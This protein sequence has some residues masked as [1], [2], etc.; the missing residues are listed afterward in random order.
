MLLSQAEHDEIARAIAD[1]ETRTSGEIFCIVTQDV[2]TYPQVPLA[3]GAV[4]AFLLP[5]ALLFAGVDPAALLPF[6]GEW[7]AA[8]TTAAAIAARTSLYAYVACQILVFVVVMLLG[9]IRAVRRMMTPRWLKRERVHKAALEQFLAKGLHVTA[10]RTGVLIFVSLGDH[11]AEIVA[12]EA[13][14]SKVTPD[15]WGDAVAALI[16]GVRSGRAANG[17][18]RAVEQCGAVLAEHFPPRPH[19]PNELPDRVVEL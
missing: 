9:Q 2:S 14:Y 12:D 19:N 7:R 6:G 4:L 15:L 13:I 18:V 10:E 17:F 11:H 16:D 1:A 5:L 3:W 8:H